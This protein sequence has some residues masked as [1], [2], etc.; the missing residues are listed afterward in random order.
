LLV[1]DDLA[2]LAEW[3]AK[4]HV[5]QWWRAPV[6]LEGIRSEYVAIIERTDPT[7]AFIV[8]ADGYPIGMIQ[9]Y[10][11]RDYPEWMRVV[12]VGATGDDLIGIDYLIGSEAHLGQGIGTEMISE[13]VAQTL[14]HHPEVTSI[15]VAVSQDNRRS[16]RALEKAGFERT[17]AGTLE[18]DDPSDLGPSYVYLLNRSSL[19]SSLTHLG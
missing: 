18:S 11:L 7:E 8:E 1:H 4:P 12:T 13:F 19:T 15:V 10:H 16:W 5:V 3:I 2:L 9:R 6:D 17:W 14:E